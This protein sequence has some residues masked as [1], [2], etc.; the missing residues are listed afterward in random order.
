MVPDNQR[1]SGWKI[2]ARRACES[3]ELSKTVSRDGA[4][5]HAFSDSLLRQNTIVELDGISQTTAKFLI[6]LLCHWIY[7]ARLAS[8]CSEELGFVIFLEEAHHVLFRHEGR[9]KETLMNVLLRQCRELG[10]GVVIIDQH[11]SLISNAG[12]GNCYTTICMNL[13]DPRD[14]HKAAGLSGLADE[15]RRCFSRLPVGQGVV[16]LQDRWRE[17]F[18]AQFPLV[19]AKKGGVTDEL[20]GRLDSG[21]ILWNEFR[22]RAGVDSRVEARSRRSVISVDEDA[23]GLLHDIAQHPSDGVDAR[24]KRLRVSAEKGNRW[25]EQLLENGLVRAVKTKKERTYRVVLQLSDEARTLMIPRSGHDP[26]ASFVHE[27]WKKRIADQ[28]EQAGYS[29]KLEAPRQRG[30][31]NVDISATKR[32]KNVAVEIETSKSDVVANV[33]RDLLSGAHEVIVVT[34]DEDAF[35]RIEWQLASAKLLIPGRVHILLRDAHVSQLM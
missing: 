3:L 15:D 12:I 19:Q 24:Y 35:N 27:Y 28:F 2:S 32:A 4:A 6:P 34:T 33:K 10:I 16:K 31:G 13:K 21:D 30:G 20:I 23:F 18:V 11:P 22:E 1:S 5:Q 25:K 8:S 7:A 17:P 9:A 26:Q 14:I 29:V